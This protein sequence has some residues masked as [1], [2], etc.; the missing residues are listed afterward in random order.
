VRW[1]TPGAESING[2][3]SVL[4]GKRDFRPDGSYITTKWI[5]LVYIPFIPLGSIRIKPSGN[6]TDGAYPFGWTSRYEVLERTPLSLKQVFSVYVYAYAWLGL[7]AMFDEDISSEGALIVAV[8]WVALPLVVRTR[9][10]K[11]EGIA[12]R[13]SSFLSVPVRDS[14]QQRLLSDQR[15]KIAFTIAASLILLFGIFVWPTQYR[16]DRWKSKDNDLPVRIHRI[17]GRSEFLMLGS[18]WVPLD[19]NRAATESAQALPVTELTRLQAK[20]SMTPDGYIECEFYNG[21]L[22]TLVDIE[23]EFVVDANWTFIKNRADWKRV[24]NSRKEP[25][26][27]IEEE[28]RKKAGLPITRR[29]RL[30]KA[31]GEPTP[32]AVSTWSANLGLRIEEWQS[33]SW[34]VVAARGYLVGK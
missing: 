30:I 14:G 26:G 18:G 16:Y 15:A 25:E 17:T 8:L 12:T 31:S 23:V 24:L 7:I 9:A 3:G 13:L 4:Y 32:L 27:V 5:S 1:F 2:I 19:A 28:L 10:R 11:V 21:T 6:A 34:R 29:Y 22:W 33:W 20:A